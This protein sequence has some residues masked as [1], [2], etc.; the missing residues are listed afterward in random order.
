MKS[1]MGDLHQDSQT[2]FL[3][4]YFALCSEHFEASRFSRSVLIGT[5]VHFKRFYLDKGSV[6][7]IYANPKDSLNINYLEMREDMQINFFPKEHSLDVSLEPPPSLPRNVS[8]Q[9]G[10]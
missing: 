6:P 1:K 3:T 5:P 10:E 2:G 9:D 4:E 7:S 8:I